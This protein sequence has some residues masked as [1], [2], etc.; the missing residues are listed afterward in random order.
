MVDTAPDS[1]EAVPERFNMARHCIGPAAHR[2]PDRPALIV[3][4]AD[5]ANDG[6]PA[7]RADTA[8]RLTFG[9]LDA[10]VR[11]VA[12]GLRSAGVR[13]GDRVVIRLGNTSA[14]PL[15][16][17]GAIAAGAVAVPTSTQL[18]TAELDFVVRDSA[19]A[20]IIQ[21]QDDTL[22]PSTGIPV[23]REEHLADWLGA[24]V[25][26]ET[27][28]SAYADTGANDPAFLV[29][30]SGTTDRP[31]GVLHAQRSIWGRRPMYA[32][33]LGLGADDVMLH[34]GAFNW[35]YT[36]GVGLSDPWACGACAV[37]YDGPR[38]PTVWPRLIDRYGATIFA[39]VPGVYRQ[40]LHDWR[41]GPGALASLRHGVVAGE[42]LAPAL[43]QAWREA[44]GVPL[45][46]ALGMSE[47]STFVSSGPTTPTRP[48][49]PGRVQP[50]RRVTVLPVDGGTESVPTGE[51]GVLAVD[52][53]EP[54]LM[55]GY[56]RRPEE[57]AASRRGPWF[58][59]SD[60]VH[61]DDD[62]YVHYH[63]RNDDVMTAQGY[64]ISPVEVEKVLAGHP[65][66]ADVAVTEVE[67]R[68]G[69]RVVAAFV[70]PRGGPLDPQDVRRYAGAHLAAYKCPRVVTV[71]DS[72]PRTPN[73]KI[74]RRDL[75]P[76]R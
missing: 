32:H 71:V 22:E 29:Y 28:E 72:L 66:I 1:L 26:S 23:V 46:E 63:G 48:G 20:V 9:E 53:D 49:S 24:D 25:A 40:W 7:G 52:R 5:P 3:A 35:T 60:L 2:G 56:W 17:F 13:R 21:R 39:A 67:V 54:G 61:L 47:I 70:V 75:A 45:Y 33:W 42:A 30:T 8:R 37:V 55:L 43:W 74:R 69:V 51:V 15:A 12:A 4:H 50:G 58:V 19:A 41:P 31:K 34:A 59:T 64:R 44:T 14:Y 10:A 27:P 65:G 57:E 76:G 62:G 11:A 6:D 68:D 73:G 16:F 36:L 38:D 18:T